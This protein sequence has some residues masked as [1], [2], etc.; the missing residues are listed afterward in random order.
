MEIHLKLDFDA[1]ELF[2][3]AWVRVLQSTLR[4]HKARMSFFAD[5]VNTHNRVYEN[6]PGCKVL[7]RGEGGIGGDDNQAD[8][9]LRGP[10][11]G[12]SC[13]DDP[14]ALVLTPSNSCDGSDVWCLNDLVTYSRSFEIVLSER[15]YSEATPGR[16][17]DRC[18]HARFVVRADQEDAK[19]A[20]KMLSES[21]R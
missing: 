10:G 1:P 17:G 4:T 5:V 8:R 15:V 6:P 9:Q 2:Q 21:G 14:N 3:D 16:V 12:V 7:D 20:S 18:V 13:F 11:P 19:I